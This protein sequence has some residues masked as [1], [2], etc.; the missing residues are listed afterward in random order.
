MSCHI[1][2]GK[3]WLCSTALG[4][5]RGGETGSQGVSEEARIVS[6][7]KHLRGGLGRSRRADEEEGNS[8][9]YQMNRR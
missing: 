9:C 6:H 4:R 7:I 3:T 1:F 5:Q 8:Q 2:G